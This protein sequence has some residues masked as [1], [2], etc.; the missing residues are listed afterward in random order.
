MLL[1]PAAAVM[2]PCHRPV[3]EEVLRL[4]LQP[5]A[6]AV[7]RLLLLPVAAAVLR[8]LLLPVAAAVLRLLLLPAA[9]AMRPCHRPVE[10]EVHRSELMLLILPEEAEGLHHPFLLRP[11][12]AV[13]SPHLRPAAAAKQNHPRVLL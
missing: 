1:Q 13:I 11:E 5:V 12:A 9:A 2:R 4:L 7:L 6:A 8:L 10:E 3:E